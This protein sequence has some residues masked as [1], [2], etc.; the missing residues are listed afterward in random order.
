ML[1][2]DENKSKIRHE[3]KQTESDNSRIRKV[4]IDKD[5]TGLLIGPRVNFN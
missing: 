3:Y 5:L 2:I 1:R 4:Y